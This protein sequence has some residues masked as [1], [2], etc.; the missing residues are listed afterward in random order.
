MKNKVPVFLSL[1]QLEIKAKGYKLIGDFI[2]HKGQNCRPDFWIDEDTFF[3]LRHIDNTILALG[4]KK[5]RY[6]VTAR[7]DTDEVE[8]LKKLQIEIDLK[9][10]VEK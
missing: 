10:E 1:E 3:R 5:E 9:E 4:Y 7:D 8:F 2:E 6:Y